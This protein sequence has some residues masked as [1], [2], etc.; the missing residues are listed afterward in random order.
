MRI[1]IIDSTLHGPIIGGAQTILSDLL[2]GLCQNGH[3]VHLIAN[4]ILDNRIEK[5]IRESGAIIHTNIWKNNL[6]LEDAA[7]LLASWVNKVKPDIYVISVSW[8]IGWLALPFLDSGIATFTIAHSNNDAFYFPARHY[9]NFLTDVIGVSHEICKKYVSVSGIEEEKIHWIPYGIR[10]SASLPD[11][12]NNNVLSLVF[13]GRLEETD[14]RISDVIAIIKKVEQK[15]IKYKFLIVG[16]GTR[17]EHIQTELAAEI[18]SQKVHLKGWLTSDEVLDILQQ[19]DVFVLTSSSEG[20]SISLIEAMANGCCPVVTDIPSGSVQLIKS[21]NNGYL[22]PVGDIEGFADKLENLSK[23]REILN[24]IR[25]AAWETGKEFSIDKMVKS[26][27]E[28][29]SKGVQKTL[30]NKRMPDPSFPIME[31]CKS[32]F[33][34]WMRKIKM[35]LTK[36]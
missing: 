10:A 25:L 5:G 15:G 3:E 2:K 7:N 4:A 34:K 26:Y 22:L 1:I 11:T 17:Y 33:P 36:Q 19:S 27:L 30:T 9:K 24:K 16:D 12:N 35:Q 20:F 29:F 31:S 23:N 8:G 14:K 18:A 28:I 6:I 13:V 32:K 21:N